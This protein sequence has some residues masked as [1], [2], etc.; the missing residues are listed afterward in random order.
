MRGIFL[1]VIFIYSILV[2]YAQKID[3]IFVSLKSEVEFITNKERKVKALIDAGDSFID[4]DDIKAEYFYDEAFNTIIDDESL[5]KAHVLLQKGRI[6]R[7]RGDYSKSLKLLLESKMIYEER[8]EENK[9]AEVLVDIGILYRYLRKPEKAIAIFNQSIQL[10]SANN[11]ST[12]IGRSYNMLGGVYR[13]LKKYDSSKYSYN[14]AQTIFK[15]LNDTIKLNEIQSNMA[16]L[17]GRQ[18]RYDKALEIHLKCLEF[19]KKLKD[20]NN[21]AT[22]YSNICF[23]YRMLKD[24]DKALKYAD[25]CLELAKEFGFKQHIASSYR[26]KS[27]IYKDLGMFDEAFVNH[28]YYKRYSDSTLIVKKDK[29]IKDI[30]LRN[31]LE[32]EKLELERINE[33]KEL[34]ANLYA[35]LSIVIFCF[36]LITALLVSRNYKERSQRAKDKLE[37]E[38]LKKEILTQKIKASETELK[39]LIA[40][41]SMRLEFIKRLTQQ[42]KDDKDSAEDKNVKRYANGLLLKLQQQIVTENKLSK[43]QDKISEVNKNFEHNIS[44][45]YPSLTKTEREICSLLRLNLSIKEIASIR[46]STTDSVKAVR[47]RIRKKM[48]IPKTQELENYIQTL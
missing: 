5:E 15:S 2:S 1:G 29:V 18:K 34:K 16:M 36:S 45:K 44:N 24:Y 27:R 21:I 12:T 46:N 9:Y 19:L 4:K 20:Q 48:E 23:E 7:T 39:N 3:S 13:V 37:K 32:K 40:D 42:I 25:S 11:D 26:S 35:T 14:K 8:K 31:Q 22:G 38:K 33:R 41:N 28:V 6:Y 30:E 47:Y 10:G 17:Y 43:L